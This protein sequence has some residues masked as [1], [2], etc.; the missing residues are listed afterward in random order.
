M[1]LP[2]RTRTAVAAS[3]LAALV[4][5][6][7]GTTS[8]TAGPVSPVG[9]SSVDTAVEDGST[10]PNIVL[11]TT[12]D[13][14]LRDFE[15]M[16]KTNRLLGE[17]GVT[18]RNALAP[19]PLCC[20]AR[21]QILTGQYA[22]NNGVRTNLPPYGGYDA[23]NDPANVLPAW[24]QAAG[25]HTVF[26]GKFLN[27]YGYGVGDID[28]ALDIPAGWDDW[29]GAY[30]NSYDYKD[31]SLNQNGTV[32][33]YTG[34]V[35][36][37]VYAS[38][39]EQKLG[40]L[41]GD[42][43]FFLWQSQLAPHG[44]YKGGR[45]VSPTASRRNTGTFAE[46]P[47]Y[48]LSSPSYNEADVS[49]KPT[50]VSELP[51][52]G[53]A[54]KSRLIER[55]RGRLDSLQDVDDAVASLVRTL[56]QVGEYDDTLILF[57]SDNGFLMGEHRYVGKVFPY[58]ESVRVPM[59][60]AGPG[61][62]AGVVRRQTVTLVDLAPT[63][64]DAADA[65]PGR[66]VDGISMLPATRSADAP[67]WDTVLL[68]AG[69][70]GGDP[71]DVELPEPTQEVIEDT[72]WLYRGVRTDRYTYARYPGTGEEEL[73]DR[74]VDPWQLDNV[75]GHPSYARVRRELAE[76]TDVL[77]KCAG[78]CFRTWDAEPRLRAG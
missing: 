78:D 62:P 27:G 71:G 13:Q 42:Q 77:G 41:A 3:A 36:A 26:M 53:E 6:A 46:E 28:P 55:N 31:F 19:H 59:L 25:Y 4:L 64:L 39:A 1:P 12:D 48:S 7:L 58:E 49:D 52:L 10:Q 69:P 23:L 74:K 63:I 70:A 17:R 68:Q 32:V 40:E 43:P 76:R 21:A 37:D 73:Y 9:A 16:P 24:V 66:V 67:G 57:T 51:R 8:A 20:P 45:W 35:Q 75:A 54:A 50:A 11:I 61:I 22:Q 30:Q 33:P 60:V 14:T 29:N 56:K 2:H 38:L 65:E 15:H 34:T 18:F 44:Q 5:A 47:L 72:N